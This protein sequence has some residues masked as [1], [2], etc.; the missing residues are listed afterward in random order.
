M[1]KHNLI[2]EILFL[3]NYLFNFHYVCCAT[4]FIKLNN[5]YISKPSQKIS[6]CQNYK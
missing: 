6:D 2:H 5:Q 1:E 3:L 4:N